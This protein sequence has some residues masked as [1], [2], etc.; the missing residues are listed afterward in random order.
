MLVQLML[1]VPLMHRVEPCMLGLFLQVA[2]TKQS[3]PKLRDQLSR[4]KAQLVSD[5]EEHAQE[6]SAL[7]STILQLQQELQVQLRKLLLIPVRASGAMPLL[8]S[9]GH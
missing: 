4:L 9:Y 7:Q 1:L 5:A 6:L 3:E 2:D 8:A